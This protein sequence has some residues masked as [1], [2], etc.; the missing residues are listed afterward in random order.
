MAR[1]KKRGGSSSEIGVGGGELGEVETPGSKY[2]LESEATSTDKFIFKRLLEVEERLDEHITQT[3]GTLGQIQQQLSQ[4]Q[5]QLTAL[6][7]KL[8]SHHHSYTMPST[9]SGGS[10]WFDLGDIKRYVDDE[11]T[12][13]DNW[14]V[15]LRG[16]SVVS[17]QQ[18]PKGETGEP[19]W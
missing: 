5:Q 2:G 12:K 10:M 16:G 8:E 19:E 3:G 15:I 11:K 6:D 17:G 9:G 18:P 4:L 14:G 13:Y 7:A 1:E